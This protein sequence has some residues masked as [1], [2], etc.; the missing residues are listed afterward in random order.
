[1][2]IERQLSLRGSFKRRV[3]ARSRDTGGERGGLY[4]CL[5]HRL[6]IQWKWE[7]R[8]RKNNRTKMWSTFATS[9]KVCTQWGARKVFDGQD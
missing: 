3:E 1:M 9:Q 7:P 2:A 4:L 6:C 5:V 8:P